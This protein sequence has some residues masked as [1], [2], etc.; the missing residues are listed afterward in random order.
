[1]KGS[2][3]M[4]D[5]DASLCEVFGRGLR[6]SDYHVQTR[7]SAKEALA[8]L[9]EQEF[10]VVLADLRLEDTDGI[11]LCERAREIQ[12]GVPVVVMTGFGS[13]DAAVAAMR[14]GA[15]DFLSKPIDLD[16]LLMCVGRAIDHRK[17]SR[18]V[19]SLRTRVEQFNGFSELIGTSPAMQRVYDVL[20]NAAGSDASV[21]LI[22]GSGT[23]KEVVART[24]HNKGRRGQG[25]FIAV[26]C[27]AIPSALLESELF[28]HKKGSFTDA[29]TDRKGLFH[30]A[31]GGT[32]FLDEIAEM[33]AV[34]Q[35]KLLRAL[36]EKRVRPIGGTQEIPF[37]VRVV[38][39]TNQD[40][41]AYIADGRFR[42]DLYYRL[43]VIRIDLPPLNARGNDVLLLAQHFLK[44][45]QGKQGKGV[46][47]I[48][49][50]AARVLLAYDWP[51]NVRELQNCIERAVVMTRFDQITVE[52]LPEKIRNHAQ[53]NVIIN[54]D[55]PTD[56]VPLAE[57]ERR[58]IL[59]VLEATKG[60]RTMAANILMLDRKTLRRKLKRWGKSD[61][62]TS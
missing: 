29:R 60:N 49:R 16:L 14:A 50:E 41:D 61:Y 19:R 1:M 33:P 12:P 3:L 36:Q 59:R 53:S 11:T 40:I 7:T 45:Q 48:S 5:D 55:N 58:Y 52:D 6:A 46:R 62:L 30:Q 4:I 57:I 44:Q 54:S 43:N 17:L 31:D 22:G 32:I 26:N 37:D 23:G 56:L 35:A 10:D 47:G 24:L 8:L 27:A 25:P 18:E 20:A 2:I 38:A 51:G 42:E 15:Y 21:L 9:R 39:A 13:F 28:G 34:M